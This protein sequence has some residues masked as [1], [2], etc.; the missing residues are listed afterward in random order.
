MDNFFLNQKMGNEEV[1]VVTTSREMI[2][3]DRTPSKNSP[4]FALET[5]LKKPTKCYIICL[6]F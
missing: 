3:P 4:S 6:T 5:N 2:T 1:K